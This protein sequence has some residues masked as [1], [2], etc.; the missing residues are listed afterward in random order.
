[1]FNCP[2]SNVLLTYTVQ[3]SLKFL[4]PNQRHELGLCF[5]NFSC[6]RSFS[7]RWLQLPQTLPMALRSADVS[8]PWEQKSLTMDTQQ[9]CSFLP[10]FPAQLLQNLFFQQFQCFVFSS[11]FV[12]YITHNCNYKKVRSDRN[13]LEISWITFLGKMFLLCPQDACACTQD[14]HPFSKVAHKIQNAK[15]KKKLSN[16][17]HVI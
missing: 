2:V 13:L 11:P 16:H 4:G 8:M 17:N 6:L 1:M 3:E 15:K 7:V 12:L 10:H 9:G 14:K 5:M